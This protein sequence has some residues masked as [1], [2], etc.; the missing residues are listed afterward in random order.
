[1]AKSLP[2][3]ATPDGKDWCLK[4]LHP[5]D[6][7]QEVRGIPDR[8]AGPTVFMNYQS[9]FT[10]SPA[11]GATGTWTMEGALYPDPVAP[12][13]VNKT[14]SIG[15]TRTNHLNPQIP[16]ADY[17]SKLVAFA[18]LAE[19]WRLAYMSVTVYQDGPDLANQGVL[20]AC[21]NAVSPLVVNWSRTDAATGQV[22]AHLPVV[23]YQ[24][25]D[26]PA[27]DNCQAM[28]NAY[29]NRSK[30][31]LYM[32]L[33]LTETCQ[34]WVSMADSS[35][36]HRSILPA[37]TGGFTIPIGVA[38]TTFPVIVNA[39]GEN[40]AFTVG[41]GD[42]ILHPANGLWGFVCARNMAITTSL[43]FFV[44]MGWELQ[45]Q[46][47]STFAPHQKLSPTYDP[48]ALDAYFSIARELKDG[49]PADYNDLGKIWDV[50]SSVGQTIAPALHLI[51]PALGA[52]VSGAISAG[53]SIRKYFQQAKTG[54][55]AQAE[56]E[57]ARTAIKSLLPKP[58]SKAKK[59]KQPPP[60][61][62]K[63]GKGGK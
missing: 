32:P 2:L 6:P 15:I 52:G 22:Q 20:T 30:E 62:K 51:H 50:I 31:G 28:P 7:L 60:G 21:Q 58:Q 40:A 10:V 1:M 53:N 13:W 41:S 5:S 16:G 18:A 63:G 59:K 43:S 27:F 17:I 12:M 23:A 54:G 49:Y 11:I 3:G 25:A 44:R 19:R 57:R 45:V 9:S 26:V 4:A 47:S 29:F 61:K 56:T 46:P 8:S 33:K 39:A 14:D 34:D 55:A 37:Y 24:N 48:A 42:V 38:T 35:Y 36:L